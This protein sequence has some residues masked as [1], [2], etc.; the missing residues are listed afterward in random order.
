[1]DYPSQ[2]NKW[3]FTPLKSFKHVRSPSPK[4]LL[5]PSRGNLAGQQKPGPQTLHFVGFGQPFCSFPRWPWTETKETT[6]QLTSS[7]KQQISWSRLV[8]YVPTPV[9]LWFLNFLMASAAS[10]HVPPDFMTGAQSRPAF[11]GSQPQVQSAK[12]GG[13]AW[14]TRLGMATHFWTNPKGW[15]I[16]YK[17]SH[18]L[19]TCL[20][21]GRTP[22][23]RDCQCGV[24]AERCQRCDDMF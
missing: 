8:Q 13:A 12:V 20:E 21:L 5:F 15:K 6:I 23:P 22:I 7:L 19:T 2:W 11:L 1:M 14:Y 9:V 16:R 3:R 17:N 10:F 24:N 18:L 4:L